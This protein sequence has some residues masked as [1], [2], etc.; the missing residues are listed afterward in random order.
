MEEIDSV[1]VNIEYTVVWARNVADLNQHDGDITTVSLVYDRGI[2]LLTRVVYSIHGCVIEEFR[3]AA[4]TG[5]ALS[6]VAGL[7][8]RFGA[9]VDPA[10]QVG[11]LPHVDEY[12]HDLGCPFVCGL[13][14]GCHSPSDTYVYLARDPLTLRYEHPV[15]FLEE[16][17]HEPWP[18]PSGGVCSAP[19]H[20]GTG[21]SFLPDSL[22]VL[23]TLGAGP[24]DGQQPTDNIVAT[25]TAFVFFNGKFGTDPTG[26]MLHRSWYWPEGR[27]SN[28]YKIR[29]GA[30]TDTEQ[31]TTYTSVVW[32]PRHETGQRTAY[33]DGR[34]RGTFDGSIGAPYPDPMTA[35]SFLAAYGT[36]SVAAGTYPGAAVLTRA[37]AIEARGGAVTLG[38]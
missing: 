18:N 25:D 5:I 10:A 7:N 28:R 3:I 27:A 19:A 17:A 12:Q 6:G 31:Y 2:D 32:P 33:V 35:A 34:A 23:G 8:E 15:V 14:F 36:M 37:C 30:F 29:A 22:E 26:I 13:C 4:P 16:G 21:V 1:L 38:R 9:I 24:V 11:V 20:D